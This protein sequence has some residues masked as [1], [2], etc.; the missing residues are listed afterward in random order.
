MM[1]DIDPCDGD[2]SYPANIIPQ[3]AA[4]GHR[5]PYYG[6]NFHMPIA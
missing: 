5:L 4:P 6:I 3:D 1:T 2:N